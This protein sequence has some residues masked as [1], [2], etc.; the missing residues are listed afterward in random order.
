ML[1]RGGRR[2]ASRA[3]RG[4]GRGARRRPARSRPSFTPDATRSAPSPGGANRPATEASEA[5]AAPTAV[6][7]QRRRAERPRD[8]VEIQREI[9]RV[10]ALPLAH[11]LEPPAF[12]R[13]EIEPVALPFP[14]DAR[15]V[16][17]RAADAGQRVED[18]GLRA[19]GRRGSRG[20]ARRASSPS[21]RPR[22]GRRRGAAR[23]GARR[24]S[25]RTADR[26][27][28]R[29]PCGPRVRARPGIRRARRTR[30]RARGRRAARP[31][32]PRPRR[33]P[34][35][36]TLHALERQ[37]EHPEARQRPQRHQDVGPCRAIG[38]PE[39]ALA[40]RELIEALLALADAPVEDRVGQPR[41][42]DRAVGAV[43]EPRRIARQ[44][45]ARRTPG[46]RACATRAR[47]RPPDPRAAPRAASRRRRR[48]A[49]TG[50]PRRPTRRRRRAP[51]ATT[52]RNRSRRAAGSRDAQ[53][54]A[55]TPPR[56]ASARA[57]ME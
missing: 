43:E 37:H 45:V 46:S 3:R 7:G 18:R 22:S 16:A 19:V 8:G 4:V 40:E 31:R 42:V 54:R 39:H 48:D 2:P 36:E 41:H 13:R 5:P 24:A 53:C 49:R 35:R 51:A 17:R 56:G 11:A 44:R 6:E 15:A 9:D 33:P 10:A 28:R 38:R 29:A 20:R 23:R 55:R 57:S 25:R 47:A 26:S 34:A 30:A 14:L 27:C 12:G 52:A 21:S 32:A 1:R 50:A